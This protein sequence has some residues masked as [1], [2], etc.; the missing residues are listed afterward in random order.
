MHLTEAHM[1][2]S[3]D[4]LRSRVKIHKEPWRESLVQ[5]L[6]SLRLIEDADY[7]PL[8]LI[9]KA[10]RKARA[11]HL[12]PLSTTWKA[13]VRRTLQDHPL[14]FR[15]CPN[16]LGHWGLCSWRLKRGQAQA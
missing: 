11:G 15:R 9:Y 14:V 2:D 3:K 16:L 13:T 6:K 7:F 5:A 1:A 4:G 10:A 12:L 8:V